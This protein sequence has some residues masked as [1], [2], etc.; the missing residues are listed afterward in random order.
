MR[1]PTIA[2]TMGDAA[3]IGPEI[4][5]KA[6]AQ[7]EVRALCNPL[8]I[9]DAERLR[10]AGEL[11]ASQLRIES[12]DDPARASFGHGNVECIDLNVVGRYEGVRCSLLERDG[13]FF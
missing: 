7:P 2:I 11:V 6:L 12:L 9:G 4:I 13:P 3:G 8:V 1:L 10:R 5:M